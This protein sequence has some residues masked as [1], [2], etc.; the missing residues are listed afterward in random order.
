MVRAIYRYPMK[1]D[2][3][4]DSILLQASGEGA[5]PAEYAVPKVPRPFLVALLGSMAL[6][7]YVA[8]PV[9]VPI[10]VAL[11]FAVAS[12]PM[13]HWF[14][15]RLGGRRHAAGGLMALGMLACIVVPVGGIALAGVH[16]VTGGLT[17][18]R[19][20][21]SSGGDLRLPE[22]LEKSMGKVATALHLRTE[23]MHEYAETAVNR[24]RN[25]ATAVLS[26]SVG[27]FGSTLAL[28]IAFYFFTV[29]LL[30]ITNFLGRITPLRP[31]QTH[32][33]FTEFRNVTRGAV[34]STAANC[35]GQGIIMFAGFWVADVPHAVFFG[36]MAVFA[37]LV[38]FV[39][40]FL[41]WIPAVVVLVSQERVTAAVLLALWCFV[42]VPV[43]DN[44]VKPLVLRGKVE[45]HGGLIALGFAGGVVVFGLPGLIAGPLVVSFVVTLLRIYQRDYLS[46]AV[47]LN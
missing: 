7:A 18:V 20:G 44:L 30:T 21:L 26:V 2:P 5:N 37:A 42:M 11:V 38:P 23:D 19:D 9:R 8:Y 29:D 36:I 39:G 33:I 16:E 12:Q 14:V 3:T 28:L 46:N 35:I 1:T 43:V 17:W 34:W 24:L 25:N 4:V 31:Q 13:Y 15:R 22:G 47:S 10:F 41:V 45:I 40:S 27:L 32:E 6:L